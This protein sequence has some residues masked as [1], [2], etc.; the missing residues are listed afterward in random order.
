MPGPGGQGLVAWERTLGDLFSEAGYATMCVGKWHI[1]DGPGRWPTDKGFDSWYGPPHSYDEALWE[2]DP[3]YRPG[4]DPV[5]HIL[6][7][8]KGQAPKRRSCCP[9]T[10]RSILTLSTT[11][12]LSTSSHPTPPRTPRSCSTTTTPSCTSRSSPEMTTEGEVAAGW[13]DCLLQLDGDFG[14]LL[15]TLS[16][17]G[18]ADNTIVVFAGDNGNEEVLLHRGTGGY[19]RVRTSPAWRRR[20]GRRALRAGQ[21]TSRRAMR[22]TKSC[23]SQT[24]SPHCC[25]WRAWPSRTTGSSTGR[26]KPR[27]C[28]ASKTSNREG[29]IYWNGERMYGV[30]WQHFKLVMVQQKYLFDPALPLGFFNIIN[31]IVDPKEREPIEPRYMHSWTMA[32]FMRI[33]GEFQSSLAREPLIP[34]GPRLISSRMQLSSLSDRVRRHH[35]RH[36]ELLEHGPLVLVVC[37]GKGTARSHPHQPAG[38]V[39][40]QLGFVGP[41]RDDEAAVSALITSD[42]SAISRRSGAAWWRTTMPAQ[43]FRGRCAAMR[44]CPRSDAHSDPPPE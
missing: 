43:G 1:G 13:A 27:F 6:E 12:G 15:D 44:V 19:W 23:M 33:L 3:W 24:G 28:A 34:R 30:K 35:D 25:R 32:H 10:S 16:A 14:E 7:S 22:A 41:K 8:T 40:D 4:R 31:L 18:V 2:Q 26:T 21:V 42:C 29:F 11:D 17:A 39:R 38:P 36:D 37:R 5:A 9:V 20:C